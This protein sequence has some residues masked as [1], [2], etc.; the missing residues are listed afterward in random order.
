MSS[1]VDQ[2]S[3][4]HSPSKKHNLSVE[5]TPRPNH[6][7]MD[8]LTTGCVSPHPGHDFQDGDLQQG[9]Q[10]SAAALDL[11]DKVTLKNNL[12]VYDRNKQVSSVNRRKAGTHSIDRA[13]I[14]NAKKEPPRL[15]MNTYYTVYEVVSEVASSKGFKECRVDPFMSSN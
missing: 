1:S 4:F 15:I 10:Q 13:S 6:S 9:K 7:N 11:R 12:K 8:K 5:L 14:A 3:Q 2:E